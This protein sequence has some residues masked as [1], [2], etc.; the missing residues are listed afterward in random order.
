V[1]WSWVLALSLAGCAPDPLSSGAASGFDVALVTLDTTRADRLG[2]YGYEKAETPNLD[3]LAREGIRYADAV[4]PAPITLVSHASILTGLDPDHHKVRHNGEYRLDDAQVTL[5]EVL[6]S[7]GYD[8]AAFISGFVLDA[9]YGLAQGFELYDDRTEAFAGQPFGGLGE[10]S[11]EA[12]TDAALEW[13]GKRDPSKPFFLWVHYYSPHADY[14]PPE[15]FAGRFPESPYDGEIAYMDSQVGR[16]VEALHSTRPKLLLVVAGDHGESFGEHSEYSHGRLLYET[17]QRVPLLLWSSEAIARPQVVDDVVV[18]LVDIFPTVLDLLG[19]PDDARRDGESLRLA[20]ERPDRAIYME[21]MMAYL[22]NGWAPL[23]ALRRREDKYI[24]APRPEY[25]RLDTDPRESKN[26][27]GQP[28]AAN[29]VAEMSLALAPRLESSSI[30]A[31]TAAAT[32][33]DP[34][35]LKRLQSL[36]YLSGPGPGSTPPGELPDP[37]DM[38]RILELAIESRTLRRDGKLEEARARARRALELAPKDLEVIE[39]NALVSLEM[40]RLDEAESG[41]RSYL[42]LKPSANICILLAEVLKRTGRQP[43]AEAYFKEAIEIEPDH[44]GAWIAWGDFLAEEHRDAEALESY[45]KAKRVDPYRATAAA[46][47][48]IVELRLRASGS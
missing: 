25:Y 21:T 20:R 18:G 14:D 24:V 3:R 7:K 10:R 43:E 40:G 48:R 1:R 8:T 5:A 44:G 6:Q 42:A 47:K 9:R 26:L 39:E 31:V 13:L 4:A 16:L 28:A 29:A 46:D 17:T 2:A 22:D 15:P 27:V 34:E 37:K 45:Q 35:S 36:G 41:L 23:F 11:A 33:P 38:V 32:K 12:V 30:E 19:I